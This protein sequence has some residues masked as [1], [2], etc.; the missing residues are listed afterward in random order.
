MTLYYFVGIENKYFEGQ[1]HLIHKTF[2]AL[3]IFSHSLLFEGC[4]VFQLL[5]L[6]GRI[7]LRNVLLS[8]WSLVCIFCNLAAPRGSEGDEGFGM[9]GTVQTCSK[10]QYWE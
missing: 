5:A 10:G 4:C 6:S 9:L 7:G 1:E 2:V 8:S 3:E